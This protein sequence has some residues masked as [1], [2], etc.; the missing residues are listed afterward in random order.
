MN[1][2]SMKVGVRYWLICAKE[3]G[4]YEK[5][6]MEVAANR[7]GIMNHVKALEI[8]NREGKYD[9]QKLLRMISDA[10]EVLEIHDEFIRLK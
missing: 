10:Q 7:E 9:N 4:A 6:Q 3:Y 2:I 1:I 8:M 5:A